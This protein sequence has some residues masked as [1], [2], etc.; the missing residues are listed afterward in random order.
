[1]IDDGGNEMERGKEKKTGNN[2]G[3]SKGSHKTNHDAI[4]PFDEP[5]LYSFMISGLALP[6]LSS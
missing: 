5:Y 1:M 2:E 4:T 6:C 3:I